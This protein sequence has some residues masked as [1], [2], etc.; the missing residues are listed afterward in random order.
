MLSS[1]TIKKSIADAYLPLAHLSDFSRTQKIKN[2]H[3]LRL[4]SAFFGF[5]PSVSFKD[6]KEQGAAF[7]YFLQFLRDFSG[8]PQQ[9][10][11]P[12]WQKIVT[13]AIF[14]WNLVSFPAKLLINVLAI[15][16]EVL[17][18]IGKAFFKR[19]AI[20]SWDYASNNEK[21]MPLR[22]LVGIGSYLAQFTSFVFAVTRFIGRSITT[23]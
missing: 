18:S 1:R 19:V 3:P 4:L 22:I 20:V 5:P 21:P 12:L 6:D 10:N 17:P 16:T 9:K 2:M 8:W 23:R 14:L 13:P 11:A 15:F 7:F